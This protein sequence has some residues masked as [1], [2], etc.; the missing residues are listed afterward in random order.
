MRKQRKWP[1]PEEVLRLVV[2]EAD[3]GFCASGLVLQRLSE[4]DQGAARRGLRRAIRQGL[5]IE[6]RGTDGRSYLSASAEG[7]RT[8]RG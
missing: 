2:A 8:L 6:R 1:A 7:W 4:H 3:D 5:L